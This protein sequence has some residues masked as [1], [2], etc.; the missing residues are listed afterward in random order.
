MEKQR[1][2]ETRSTAVWF[3][4]I[5]Q[6]IENIKYKIRHVI[7]TSQQAHMRIINKPSEAETTNA[8]T[9]HQSH[10]SKQW[11]CAATIPLKLKELDNAHG[12]NSRKHVHYLTQTQHKLLL[13][14]LSS[15]ALAWKVVCLLHTVWC[16]N[17]QNSEEIIWL[18]KKLTPYIVNNFWLM[19]SYFAR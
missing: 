16:T 1:G 6:F 4:F 12:P 7:Q 15:M 19:L 2:M 14:T 13:M 8:L 9:N 18:W 10:W 3:L 11:K 17:L 5:L